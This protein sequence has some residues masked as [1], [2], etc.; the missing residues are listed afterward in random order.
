MIIVLLPVVIHLNVENKSVSQRYGKY[1]L[2]NIVS[3]ALGTLSILGYSE[4]S[5]V[6]S[7]RFRDIYDSVA[8]YLSTKA[9][10]FSC[11]P[12]SLDNNKRSL[13]PSQPV[14]RSNLVDI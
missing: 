2:T 10:H 4:G 12:S 7:N 1:V 13:L 11:N 3:I 14:K 8:N 6:I 5:H 9:T